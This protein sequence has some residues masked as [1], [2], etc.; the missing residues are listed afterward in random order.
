[1]LRGDGVRTGAATIGGKGGV[2]RA[3][4]LHTIL[5]LLSAEGRV[6]VERT[7][8]ALAVSPATVRRDLDHLARQQVLTRTH[9]GAVS[10]STAYDL[11]LR[12]KTARHAPEKRRIAECA[13]SLVHPGAV[14]GANGGTTTTEVVRSL[15]T[16][17]DLASGNGAGSGFALTVV[18]N[19][20]N[21]AN[22]LT[23]RAAVKIVVTGGVARPQSY[24][25]LGPLAAQ[26]LAEVSL[27]VA[28]I[29]VDALDL[30]TGAM[31]HHEGEAGINRLLTAR[32]QRVV[33][34]T[35]SSKLGQ[36]AFARICRPEE[37][38][39]VVTDAG[40]PADVVSGLA[41]AGVDVRQV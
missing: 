9:G 6:D 4:R 16:R 10:N 30:V 38:D 31:C 19:A 21:I 12:Y 29:G 23:V 24:E 28:F 11:P 27:D 39:V 35:D 2:T 33:V 32:A 26:T 7:A 17:P 18:T 8:A 3:E 1:V 14:V 34:V 37:I 15:A 5:E 20:L 22:E 25:L 13:A 40:A 36:R 41:A